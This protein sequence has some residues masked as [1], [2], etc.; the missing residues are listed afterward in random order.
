MSRLCSFLLRLLSS[1]LSLTDNFWLLVYHTLQI[2]LLYNTPA[3]IFSSCISLVWFRHSHLSHMVIC[4]WLYITPP[5]TIC[6][7]YHTRQKTLFVYLTL[8]NSPIYLSHIICF[9]IRLSHRVT[10]QYMHAIFPHQNYAIPSCPISSF[11]SW[12]LPNSK[13]SVADS[14]LSGFLKHSFVLW[15][16]LWQIFQNIQTALLRFFFQSL[17]CDPQSLSLVC[18]S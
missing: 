1:F 9:P 10:P 7:I 18:S 13:W 5:W 14:L 6:L 17:W 12:L 8:I 3:I 4:G 11:S 15:L 2:F 16:Y